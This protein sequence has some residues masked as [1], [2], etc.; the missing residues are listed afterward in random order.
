MLIKSCQ[1][2]KIGCIICHL[3]VDVDHFHWVSLLLYY[4][5]RTMGHR[6]SSTMLY[7][8][9]VPLPSDSPSAAGKCPRHIRTYDEDQYRAGS[10]VF[11]DSCTKLVRTVLHLTSPLVCVRVCVGGGRGV[12]VICE[13]MSWLSCAC[14]RCGWAQHWAAY[15]SRFSFFSTHQLNFPPP[16]SPSMP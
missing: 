6:Y 16:I 8:D 15:Q 3:S 4:R 1:I 2:L 14:V 5:Y 9:F 13:G 11:R 7:Q 10:A 12:I